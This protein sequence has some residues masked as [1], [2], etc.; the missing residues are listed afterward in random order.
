MKSEVAVKQEADPPNEEG[1][2][3][4]EAKEPPSETQLKALREK[5]PIN[6]ARCH[7]V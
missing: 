2:Q 5:W 3:G 4:A 6:K 1:E 7:Y